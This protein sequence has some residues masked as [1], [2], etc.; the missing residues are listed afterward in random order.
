MD[1]LKAEY[2]RRL[3][4]VAFVPRTAGTPAVTPAQ[5][6]EPADGPPARRSVEAV[7][8]PVATAKPATP[9]TEDAAQPHRTPARPTASAN[10][11]TG[12]GAVSAPLPPP[13]DLAALEACVASC[14][15][16]ELHRARSR[17]VFGSGPAKARWMIVGE[18]PGAE[19]DRQG[20]PFVGRAGQLLTSMIEALGVARESVYIANTVKC[21]PPQNR[22]PT[23]EEMAACR[24]FLE[25]QIAE[26][27][28]A[29]ILAVGRIAAQSL[30]GSQE[31][32]GRLR[33]RLH[34]YPGSGIPLVVT[35]HPAYLLRSPREKR[36]AWEDLL[37]ARGQ[38]HP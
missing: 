2:L 8:P 15:G 31:P 3:G 34:H 7:L 21:R 19:E 27:E 29:L 35:Y 38:V 16:C 12:A 23:A 36:K 26:V 13:G 1:P 17:T 11:D 6:L 4:I 22:D 14:R 10:A 9:A 37:Y 33:G 24:P 20:L 5:G 25:R 30:L 32:L 28:P 18:G